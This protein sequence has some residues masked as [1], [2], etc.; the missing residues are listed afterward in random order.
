MPTKHEGVAKLHL[1]SVQPKGT[2]T[3]RYEF[4]DSFVVPP[5]L[6]MAIPQKTKSSSFYAKK[7]KHSEWAALTVVVFAW[8][9]HC[10][11]V[12]IPPI[13]I[14]NSVKSKIEH[15]WPDWKDQAP[16][17]ESGALQQ[18]WPISKA[19]ARPPATPVLRRPLNRTLERLNQ[20]EASAFYRRHE[21]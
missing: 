7:G 17:S 6:P 8:T 16:N 9:H 4:E 10:V 1:E 21:H 3:V 2:W 18:R 12:E 14:Q 15:S 13:R 19:G 5:D 20:H 11:F